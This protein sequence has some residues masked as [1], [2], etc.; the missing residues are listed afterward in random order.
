MAHQIYIHSPC[1]VMRKPRTYFLL[2]KPHLLSTFQLSL[3]GDAPPNSDYT[4]ASNNLSIYSVLVKPAPDQDYGV[5]KYAR[6]LGS[7]D[8]STGYVAEQD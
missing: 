4:V 7:T 6:E 2:F 5:F 3:I 8:K 1:C